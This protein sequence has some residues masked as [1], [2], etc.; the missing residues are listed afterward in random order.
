VK[1]PFA[2]LAVAA[3]AA[4]YA[5]S[6]NAFLST[7]TDCLSPG[8]LLLILAYAGILVLA[9]YSPGQCMYRLLVLREPHRHGAGEVRKALDWAGY[10][11]TRVLFAGLIFTLTEIARVMADG[12]GMV[13]A[14]AAL[15][16]TLLAA[17]YGLS[18]YL[19]IARGCAAAMPMAVRAPK[20]A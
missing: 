15:T 11:G 16:M 18:L 8:T 14:A 9:R 12:R 3:F 17:L 20:A 1:R 2:V 10:V 6:S 19:A 4:A 13:E 7:V 5:S